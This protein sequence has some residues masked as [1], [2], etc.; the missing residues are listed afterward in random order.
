[1][2][3]SSDNLNCLK[4]LIQLMC[5][6]KSIHKREK[7]FL[8]RA[9]K[10]LDVQVEDWNG[11]LKEVL[12]NDVPLY[13]VANRDKAVAILKSMIVMSK[14]DGDIHPSEKQ[15]ALQ[16]AKSI[17][18]SKTEWKQILKDIDLETLFEPFTK[19]TGH[20]ITI[21]DDF[22]KLDAFLQVA[23]DNGAVTDSVDLQTFLQSAYNDL[24]VVCFHA[25]E[26]KDATVTRCQMLLEM[27]S[28]KLVCILTRY[29]GHQVKYLLEIG[30]KKC[31][32]EPV[33][34]RDINELLKH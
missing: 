32:I 15:L 25:A 20:I 7:S 17:G 24:S 16:F 3:Q 33:Y 21:H 8:S 12:T 26:D 23:E 2:V 14:A 18:V 13:P 28:D 31:I 29:Q 10:E 6:D 22:D 19:T 4:N 34:T 30:L 11:L 9:A 5:C 27:C 1:M